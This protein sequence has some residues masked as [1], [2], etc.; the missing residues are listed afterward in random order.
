MGSVIRACHRRNVV[1]LDEGLGPSF[2]TWRAFVESFDELADT[3]EFG[4]GAAV[5]SSE[6]VAREALKGRALAGE[7]N[8]FTLTVAQGAQ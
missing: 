3:H 2:G 4:E 7:Q 8:R 5:A 6:L 1:A